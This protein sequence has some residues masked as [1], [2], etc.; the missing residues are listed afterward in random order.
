M[1]P[2]MKSP[3]YFKSESDETNKSVSVLN[4]RNVTFHHLTLFGNGIIIATVIVALGM[5]LY[6][7][8]KRWKRNKDRHSDSD[9]SS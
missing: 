9:D 8:Y 7:I 1:N 2:L 5:S 6:F 4:L 3:W